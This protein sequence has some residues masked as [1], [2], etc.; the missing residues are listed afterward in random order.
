M[1]CHRHVICFATDDIARRTRPKVS[2][3]EMLIDLDFQILKSLLFKVLSAIGVLN[4]SL[5][6]LFGISVNVRDQ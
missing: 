4:D 5:H 2:W 3:A 6:M 1:Y